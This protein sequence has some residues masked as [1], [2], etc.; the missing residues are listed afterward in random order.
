MFDACP[1]CPS[2]QTLAERITNIAPNKAV[3]DMAAARLGSTNGTN[4]DPKM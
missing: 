2:K 1:L 3:A 4:L